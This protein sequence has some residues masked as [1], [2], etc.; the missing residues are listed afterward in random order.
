MLGDLLHRY[1]T[2]RRRRKNWLYSKIN[3]IS[4]CVY[5]R[6]GITFN[7]VEKN[8]EP[9]WSGCSNI[10]LLVFENTRRYQHYIDS[11]N[12]QTNYWIAE[13]VYKRLR[14]LNNRNLSQLGALIFLAVWHG[15]HSGYYVAFAIEFAVIVFE[16][17]VNQT[18][19]KKN[20]FG[21]RKTKEE[22]TTNHIHVHFLDFICRWHP[23][24][25]IAK[26]SKSLPKH[27]P[28]KSSFG[29][30]WKRTQYLAWDSV[31]HRW[32]CL[33]SIDIGLCIVQCGIMATSYGYL[34]PFINHCWRNY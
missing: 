19:N 3:F 32:C 33:A 16:R 13:Y 30:Y 11:F 24:L 15:F 7:G 9:D 31:F 21:K 26:N 1:K 29:W 22:H 28:V 5:F 2:R 17:E 10:K 27:C 8:G 12:V 4:F 14:F 34:G 6:T 18:T 25:I 23:F 20:F